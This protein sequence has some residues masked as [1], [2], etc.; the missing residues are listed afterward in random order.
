MEGTI[1]NEGFVGR[2]VGVKMSRV[3]SCSSSR[4]EDVNE[5]EE[6]EKLEGSHNHGQGN[7]GECVGVWE[8]AMV[9]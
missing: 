8:K 3:S 6:E 7:T 4:M 5:E 1:G 2:A 9:L